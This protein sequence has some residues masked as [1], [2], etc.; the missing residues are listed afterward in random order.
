MNDSSRF[1]TK[2]STADS[3]ISMLTE[4]LNKLEKRVLRVETSNKTI[5]SDLQDQ[6]RLHAKY[7]LILQG[8]QVPPRIQNEDTTSVFI[9]CVE[10]KYGVKVDRSDLADCHRTPGSD[11]IIARFLSRIQ[12]SPYDKL[13]RRFDEWDPKKELKMYVNLAPTPLDSKFDFMPQF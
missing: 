10:R 8:P 2:L 3:R 6:K 12:D 1:S 5:Q 7:N 11:Q 13:F 4:R 9:E